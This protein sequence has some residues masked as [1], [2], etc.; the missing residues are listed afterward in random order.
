MAA[1]SSRHMLFFLDFAKQRG[2]DD[3]SDDAEGV[4]EKVADG[5]IQM[6]RVTLK[7][8]I[9]KPTSRQQYDE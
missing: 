3:E 1:T 4:V 5:R 7:P 2:F 9:P 8:F 6:T